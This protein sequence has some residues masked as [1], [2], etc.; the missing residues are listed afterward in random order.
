MDEREWWLTIQQDFNR[1]YDVRVKG[2]SAYDA[3]SRYKESNR[4]KRV[5]QVRPVAKI[6]QPEG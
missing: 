1:T 4:N 2:V 3:I 5:I 6:Q